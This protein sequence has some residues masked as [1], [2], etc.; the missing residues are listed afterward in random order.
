MSEEVKSTLELHFYA[1]YDTKDCVYV[2]PFVSAEQSVLEE[3]KLVV[4]DVKSSYYG[5]E[6]YYI[7]YD[8]GTYNNKNGT[9]LNLK[10]VEVC[11]LDSLI[12]ENIRNV[13]VCIQ[14]LNY[15]PK[16]Y[17]KAPKEMQADVQSKIDE[18]IKFY[19]KEFIEKPLNK[20]NNS[21]T[22]SS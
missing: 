19:T 18:A 12:D 8:L 4:N 10:P 17:F 14:T 3:I 15:L 20:K 2:A 5:K 11:H 22:I 6:K 13:Q 16:G 1:L 9:V 21:E 7:L